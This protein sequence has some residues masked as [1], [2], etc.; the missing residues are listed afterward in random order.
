MSSVIYNILILKG[1]PI[2]SEAHEF[3]FMLH[4]GK[5]L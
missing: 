2:F 5:V 3:I 4:T 1:V